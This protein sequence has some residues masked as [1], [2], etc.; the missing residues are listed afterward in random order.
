MR[1]VLGILNEIFAFGVSA[2]TPPDDWRVAD[3]ADRPH[4][5]TASNPSEDVP[6]A[7]VIV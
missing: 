1:W 2:L 6:P 4:T 5:P 3:H 7:R